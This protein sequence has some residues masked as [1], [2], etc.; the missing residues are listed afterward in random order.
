MNRVALVPAPALNETFSRVFMLLSVCVRPTM[1]ATQAV[2]SFTLVSAASVRY[3]VT[4]ESDDV[5]TREDSKRTS[6]PLNPATVL[7]AG[8]TEN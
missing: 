4:G 3:K 8:T 6:A 2:A 5:A 7:P 1:G